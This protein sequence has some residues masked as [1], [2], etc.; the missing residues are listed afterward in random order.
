MFWFWGIVPS[1]Q[2]SNHILMMLMI[3]LNMKTQL[4]NAPKIIS[5]QFTSKFNIFGLLTLKEY[6]FEVFQRARRRG[7]SQERYLSCGFTFTD[8]LSFWTFY[9]YVDFLQTNRRCQH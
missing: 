2:H 4:D 7:K 5:I 8:Y 9:G 6:C 3:M 1:L